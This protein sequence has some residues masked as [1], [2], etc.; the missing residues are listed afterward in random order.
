MVSSKKDQPPFLR[1]AGS[2][3]KLVP[4][5]SQYWKEHSKRYVEPFMGSAC[6]FFSLQP[7][8]A[9]LSDI[10]AELV[11]VF[12]SVKQ[13]PNEVHE[14]VTAIPKGSD[15]YYKIRSQDYEN[16]D[17]IQKAGRFLFLNRYCFNGLYRT[18]QNGR[19]NVPF[20]NRTGGIPTV[21]QF[22]SA[23]EALQNVT[24]ISGDFESVIKTSILPD[25]FVYLDPPYAVK[26]QRIF[27]QYGPDT[28]GLSDLERLKKTLDLID[29]KGA[30]F[31]LS[32]ADCDE[33][34]DLLEKWNCDH[35]EVQ[36]NIAGFVKHRRKAGEL[37]FTNVNINA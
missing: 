7:Q 16:F 31:L 21:E 19:F 6:L 35:V 28:F 1:W 30:K 8:S 33:I 2:K 26:N 10:N 36:R 14:A 5:L 34:K 20:G 17:S 24:L 13:F 12:E 15:S 3:R 9:L 22:I 25:D 29:S 11:E 23:S 37:L 4:I 32:Y 18:N 27:N